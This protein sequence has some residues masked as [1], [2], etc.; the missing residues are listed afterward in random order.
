MATNVNLTSAYVGEAVNEIFTQ[1][2]LQANTLEKN[3]IKV[4]PNVVGLQTYL[5]KTTIADAIADYTCT[6]QPT[7]D[8]DLDEKSATLKALQLNLEICK[9]EFLSRWSASQMGFGANLGEIPANER[10]ALLKEM[11]GL[12]SA[13]IERNI[14]NGVSATAGQFGGIY[15]ELNGDANA[16]DVTG[17][18]LT[19]ANIIA[20]MGKLLD[21]TPVEV[22]Q[23]PNFKFAMSKKAHQKYVRA[24]GTAYF[25][26]PANSFEG[27]EIE[28]LNG[29]TDN[30][31]LT[32]DRDNLVF[33]TGLVGEGNEIRTIDMAETTG[34]D[35][36]RFIA[37]FKAA[38]TYVRSEDVT[39]YKV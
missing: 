37:N 33:L 25:S 20:E 18:A 39:F 26:Q 36:V 30:Q 24:L 4:I 3:A 22:L 1:I 9:S 13:S 11:S 31:M 12:I 10:E 21:A 38:A 14:W 28:V 23:S 34:D 6:F 15:T 35:T 5:Q 17:V 16:N 29:L 32:Y 8:V 27:Y 19:P 7:G 2:F